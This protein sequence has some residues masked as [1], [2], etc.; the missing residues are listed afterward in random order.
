MKSAP[1]ETSSSPYIVK[2]V[3]KALHVLH[4]IAEEGRELTLTEVSHKARLP[5]TTAYRYLTTLRKWRLVAYVPETDLYRLGPYLLVLAQRAGHSQALREAALPV[6]R[7]LRDDYNETV[8]L[9]ELSGQEVIYIEIVA[10]HRS[11]RM[12]AQIGSR[13]P[14]YSTAVGKALLAALPEAQWDRRLPDIL[15]PRTAH[16]HRSRETLFAELALTRVRGYA[17]DRCENEEGAICIAAPIQDRATVV[18]AISVSAPADRIP[19]ALEPEIARAVQEAAN[20]ISV[21]LQADASRSD[22]PSE[23]NRP[24]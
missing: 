6:M 17:V 7:Q 19:V 1:M 21:R 20:V 3:D 16:T 10:S 11:L 15:Q 12:Q 24:S 18:A 5:K 14:A 23:S 4:C 13:D 9:C 8:N 22:R 2:P